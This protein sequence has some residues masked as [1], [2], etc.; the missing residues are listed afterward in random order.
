M[1]IRSIN[2][3]LYFESFKIHRH[4]FYW[5]VFSTDIYRKIFFQQFAASLA[6]FFGQKIVLI[7]S[8]KST[9]FSDMHINLDKISV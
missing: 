6:I 8:V 5:K 9:F 4:C 1:Q 2:Y 7:D 3:S